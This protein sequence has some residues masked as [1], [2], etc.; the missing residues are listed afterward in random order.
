MAKLVVTNGCFDLFHVGHLSLL[1]RASELGE[2][3]VLVNSD[4]SVKRLKGPTRPIIPQDQRVAIIKAIRYVSHVQLFDSDTPEELI[5][6]IQPDYLVKGPGY[7]KEQIAGHQYA[8]ET[9]I[10]QHGSA[11]STS[12]IIGNIWRSDGNTQCFTVNKS[13]RPRL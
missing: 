13:V 11:V 12:T 1:Q 8:K 6:I 3:I 9:I 2:L 4:E 5:K 10:L 7:T